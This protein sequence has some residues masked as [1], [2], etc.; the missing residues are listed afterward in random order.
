MIDADDDCPAELGPRLLEWANHARSDIPVAVVLAK[1]EFEA[2]FL[3][4]AASLGG[5]RG[6]CQP[7]MAPPDPERVRDAKGW[8]SRNMA[9]SRHYSETLDQA[10][11]AAVFDLQAARAADSFDKCYRE[12]RRLI[13]AS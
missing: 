3:A 6:L 11:L 2:W 4:A 5:R 8:L 13:G 10:A 1:V 9:G 12:I 7:L